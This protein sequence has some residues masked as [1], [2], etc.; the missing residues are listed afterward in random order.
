MFIVF[1][2]SQSASLNREANLNFQSYWWSSLSQP[3]TETFISRNSMKY[4]GVMSRLFTISTDGC[5]FQRL[6]PIPCTYNNILVLVLCRFSSDFF[7]LFSV[8]TLCV[9]S[10][11][12]YTFHRT[13]IVFSTICNHAITFFAFLRR[14]GE[15][16]SL[17][18]NF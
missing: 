2:K 14:T 10:R 11:Y 12:R 17:I 15:L 1:I 9:H 18:F 13:N 4:I 8:I 16:A 7:L 6:V 3:V 5:I